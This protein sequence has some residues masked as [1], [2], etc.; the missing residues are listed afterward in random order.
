MTQLLLMTMTPGAEALVKRISRRCTW[1]VNVKVLIVTKI[2]LTFHPHQKI[3]WE[4]PH[5]KI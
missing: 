5:L 2:E 1:K 4:D 3:C